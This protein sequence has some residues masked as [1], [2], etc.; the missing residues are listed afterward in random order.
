M[1]YERD[2]VALEMIFLNLASFAAPSVHS[3]L[4]L[5]EWWEDNTSAPPTPAHASYRLVPY[6]DKSS[7]ELEKG[8]T[9][10]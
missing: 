5:T 8:Y 3:F 4:G 6:E 9:K 7:L 10:V 1:N 2:E